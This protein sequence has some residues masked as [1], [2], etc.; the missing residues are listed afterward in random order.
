[1]RP[2]PARVLALATGRPAVRWFFEYVRRERA[3]ELTIVEIPLD[4]SRLPEQLGLIAEAGVAVVDTGNDPVTAINLCRAIRVGRP[5][6]PI[7][8][9]ACCTLP[10]T[11]WHLRE[12]MA[13]EGGCSLLDTESTVDELLRTV[14]RLL[15]GTTSMHLHRGAGD[16]VGLRGLG[17][18]PDHPPSAIIGFDDPRDLSLVELVARGMSDREIATRL[19]LSPHTVHHRIER[20]RSGLGVRNRIELAAWAGRH[21]LYPAGRSRV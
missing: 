1:L 16:F 15:R 10:F 21:G 8:A 14:D 6:L 3:P 20:L 13:L 2:T 4:E 17:N 11:P 5:E 19:H 12:L 18:G 7:I 9:L